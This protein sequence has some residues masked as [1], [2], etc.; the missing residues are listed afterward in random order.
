MPFAL[1]GLL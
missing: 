1:G